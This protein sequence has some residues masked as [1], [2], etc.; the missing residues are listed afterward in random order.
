MTQNRGKEK[1]IL[2]FAAFFF[3][4]LFWIHFILFVHMEYDFLT[5]RIR[6]GEWMTEGRNG[7]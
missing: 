5:W 3:W 2:F 6:L 4:M 1:R 7:R